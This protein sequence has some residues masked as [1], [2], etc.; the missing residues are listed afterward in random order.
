MNPITKEIEYEKVKTSISIEEPIYHEAYFLAQDEGMSF[1]RFV[2]EALKDY[3]VRIREEL[4]KPNYSETELYE[5]RER[6]IKEILEENR[7]IQSGQITPQELERAK[8]DT[9][10]EMK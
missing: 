4:G 5:M 9:L 3:I 8:K 2:Q 1:S 10:E 7:M 6:R